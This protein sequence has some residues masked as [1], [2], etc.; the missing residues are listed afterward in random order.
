MTNTMSA[1]LHQLP[2]HPAVATPLEGFLA[3]VEKRAY[4]TALLT[5]RSSAD[6][7]DI[8]QDAMLKLVQHY[9]ERPEQEWPMLFQRILQNAILDWHREQARHRRWFWQKPDRDEME[10]A[11]DISDAPGDANE[12]PA[13]IFS[14]VR[15]IEVVLAAL[16]T[17]PLRQRQAF[18]LRAW[19]GF[20]TATTAKAMDCSE[21]SVKTHFFRAVQ[22][23][24]KSLD[25]I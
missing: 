1:T 21:G 4:R 22:T 5:T 9:R 17:L 3:G 10:D 11:D 13:E 23:L 14:R 19:E 25:T 24:K 8:V 7:L 2:K 16:E 18:L 15:N 20:D 12:N 6:A